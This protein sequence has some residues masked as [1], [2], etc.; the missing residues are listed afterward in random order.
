M[1]I[2]KE[3]GR[4]NKIALAVSAVLTA[5]PYVVCLLALDRFPDP[6]PTHWNAAGAADAW[7]SKYAFFGA[8][9]AV[10]VL[11]DVLFHLGA[12]DYERKK[13]IGKMAGFAFR[14]V[15]PVFSNLGILLLV[16]KIF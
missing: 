11:C 15:A 6:V 3:M 4:K 8:G 2:L 5:A 10:F 1:K 16:L 9:L 14:I 13:K 7:D 12:A